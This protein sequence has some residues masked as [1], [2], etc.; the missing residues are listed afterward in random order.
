[1]EPLAI[2]MF[3]SMRAGGRRET[4]GE[5]AGKGQAPGRRAGGRDSFM[6]HTSGKGPSQQTKN[7]RN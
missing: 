5:R 6:V 3:I 4:G 1:M 7:Q 2:S